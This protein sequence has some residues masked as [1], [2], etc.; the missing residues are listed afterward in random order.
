MERM[1][2][3]DGSLREHRWSE[4]DG[5]KHAAELRRVQADWKTRAPIIQTLLTPERVRSL[6]K[7]A[8][9]QMEAYATVPSLE[10]TQLQPV[11]VDEKG[12]IIVL[13]STVDTL[14]AHNPLVTRWLKAYVRYDIQGHRIVQLTITIRGQ[15]LE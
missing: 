12:G 6:S 15:V 9:K 5:T 14:P 10:K 1:A 3:L 8:V 11:A 13:E 2:D 4:A 7:W